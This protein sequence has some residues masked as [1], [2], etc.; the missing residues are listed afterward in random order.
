MVE[1]D[2][3]LSEILGYDAFKVSLE[4]GQKG[5][6]EKRRNRETEKRRNCAPI[7][8]FPDSPIPQSRRALY[9]VKVPTQQIDTV[10]GLG[11]QGFYV[12]DV[13]VTLSRILHPTPYTLHSLYKG[14]IVQD[15]EPAHYNAVLDIA[16]SCFRYSR[17]HLDPAIPDRLAHAVKR[18]WVQSY[19]EGN[20]GERLLVALLDG[21][22]AGFLAVLQTTVQG[23]PCRVIDLIGVHHR[24]QGQGVGKALVTFLIEDSGGRYPAI[25]VGTQAANIPSLR[26]YESLGF[27][28]QETT[29][30]LHAH[31]GEVGTVC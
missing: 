15:I 9:Y 7:P 28:M 8:R 18:A 25:R 10:R 2:T 4:E 19:I 26:L 29:Y 13:N 3:W 1:H 20:R 24:C 21:Q 12:V 31:V 23:E 16:G 11:A 14:V 5:G 27:H 6:V 22:P 17:F 30:V